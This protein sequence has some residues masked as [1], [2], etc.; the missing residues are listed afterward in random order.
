M[1]LRARLAR[2]PLK[3]RILAAGIAVVVALA[4]A[5]WVFQALRK[6]SEVFFPLDGALA[7]TPAQTWSEYGPLFREHSTA[8]MTPEL[9][10]ALAQLEGAGNPVARTYWRWRVAWNPTEVYRPASSAVGMYQITDARFAEAK[11]Y[12]IRD[13]LP[14]EDGAWHDLRSCWFNAFYFRVLPSHAVE[15]TSAYLDRRVA[16]LLA[17][18][19]IGGATLQQKQDLAGVIHLCGAS[20]A[21]AYAR[22]GFRPAVRER[23]GEHDLRAYLARLH[24]LKRNFSLL[25]R[26]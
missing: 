13:H 19:R 1:F 8:V 25:S 4:A 5:N 14:V 6:P 11:R 12:C 26:A 22:R 3:L 10:A 23:C 7:K 24:A 2:V 17:Q 18:Q 21:E 15:M 20:V 16:Q 9:L